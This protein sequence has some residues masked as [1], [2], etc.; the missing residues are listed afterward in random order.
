MGNVGDFKSSSVDKIIRKND[1]SIFLL[2]FMDVYKGV[3]IT[4]KNLSINTANK[5]FK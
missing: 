2:N 1:L 5:S 4:S 3:K